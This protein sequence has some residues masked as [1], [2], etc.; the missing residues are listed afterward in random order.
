[1]DSEDAEVITFAEK[2][3]ELAATFRT[4]LDDVT[5]DQYWEELGHFRH[6]YLLEA[7]KRSRGLFERFPA[8]VEIKRVIRNVGREHEAAQLAKRLQ[9]ESRQI[10]RFTFLLAMLKDP[11]VPDW[12]KTEI[13]DEWQK[14]FG[15]DVVPPWEEGR[16]SNGEF[17]S[18]GGTRDRSREHRAR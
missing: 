14:Q 8:P 18:G 13:K 7:L 1:M 11:D 9:E 4:S 5:T 16:V 17:Q 15:A 12:R 3:A 6:D 10:G 2:L